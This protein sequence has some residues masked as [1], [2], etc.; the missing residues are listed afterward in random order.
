MTRMIRKMFYK[1]IELNLKWQRSPFLRRL[2][3][4]LVFFPKRW[5]RIA[6]R[7]PLPITECYSKSLF[8]MDVS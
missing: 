4:G 6:F 3:I 5:E 7:F 8:Q 1:V 2:P